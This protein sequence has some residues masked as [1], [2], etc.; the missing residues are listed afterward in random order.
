[1]FTAQDLTF[2]QISLLFC[3]IGV[4]WFAISSFKS[5]YRL[6][7]IPGP[8]LA[9][10]SYLWL[11][12]VAYSERQYY[13]HR[14]LGSKYGPLVRVGPNE[15]TTDD[16]EVLRKISSA[17]SSYGKDDWYNGARFNPYFPTTLS[18]LDTVTHDTMKA[19]TTAA[20]SGRDASAL[21]PQVDA[22]VK[23][24]L[25]LIRRKYISE[26]AT[27]DLRLLDFAQLSSFFTLDVIT[28]VGFGKE[29]GYLNA[30]CDLYDW[31]SSL[32][33]FW[34]MLAISLDTP[35]IR[36]ILYSSFFL[37]LFGP[38]VTDATGVGRLMK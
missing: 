37:K 19:K 6:R 28:G 14:E 35:W 8:F 11:A 15:I 7:H 38:K 12:R 5:W 2:T 17:R 22:Q 9:S 25:A 23:D 13:V 32:R 20:Y 16:P 34:P 24:L 27:Q 31:F 3:S 29:F 36:A 26:P 21:E 18:T 1:M 30:D 4:I 33:D 10:I